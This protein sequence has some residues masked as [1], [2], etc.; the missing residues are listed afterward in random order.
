M[1]MRRAVDTRVLANLQRVTVEKTGVTAQAVLGRPMFH[2]LGDEAD[3]AVAFIA[4]ALHDGGAID[5]QRIDD[6]TEGVGVPCRMRRLGGGNQQFAGHATDAC[7]GGPVRPSLDHQRRCGYAP[8][9]RGR[10]TF[11]QCRRR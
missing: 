11:R 10:R 8:A 4:N 7:A 9:R 6:D 3:E 5:A 1:T 2:R